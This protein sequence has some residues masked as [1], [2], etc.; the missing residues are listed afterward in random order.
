MM[1]NVLALAGIAIACGGIGLFIGISYCVWPLKTE[2][3]S[4]SSLLVGQAN[5]AADAA[6]HAIDFVRD[7]IGKAESEL[8]IAR[9]ELAHH[10]PDPVEVNPLVRF[11]TVRASQQL[12]GSVERAQGAVV[13]ASDAV[14]VADMALN[15][16]GGSPELKQLIGVDPAQMHATR[17]ALGSVASE[18]RQAR[19]VLGGSIGSSEMIP[20]SDQLNAVDD[21]LNRAKNFT[22]QMA[23]VVKTARTRVNDT[24]AALDLWVR[25][26][27]FAITITCILGAVGQCFMLRFCWRKFHQKPA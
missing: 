24:K 8:T 7:I 18:L 9:D 11:A 16:I 22:D 2:V 3:N 14:V 17:T 13:A 21:A 4:Q 1:R 12:A 20:T 26:L 10:P 6:D 23:N 25:R 27:A 19:S 5:E 15:I